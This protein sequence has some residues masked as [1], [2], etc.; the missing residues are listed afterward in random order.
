LTPAGR[1]RSTRH[2]LPDLVLGTEWIVDA[3]GC[4]P[5]SLRSSAGLARLFARIVD[6][7]GL[8]PL[9]DPVWHVFPGP[10]GI[11]GLLL[12]RESHL[13]CHTFPERAFAAIDLYC[14]RPSQ[15]W[16]WAERLAEALGAAEVRVRSMSRGDR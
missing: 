2:T 13:A 15:E 11:T 1:L 3:Y 4:D 8:H 10:G 9:S 7:L 6:E 5:T 14:C 12:L 16:P